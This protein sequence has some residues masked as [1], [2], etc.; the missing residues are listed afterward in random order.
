MNIFPI[1]DR[2]VAR[3]EKELLLDQKG[4]AFWLTGLSGSG[5]STIALAVERKLIDRKKMV[6]LLDGDNVR[7]GLCKDLS[8]SEDDRRENIRRISEL[9]KIFVENGLV[10]LCTFIS[11]LEKMRE[12]AKSIIGE[13]DFHL[14]FVD[15]PIDLCI[16]RDPKGLYAKAIRGEIDNFTGIGAPYEPPSH[17]DLV[18]DTAIHSLDESSQVLFDYILKF[19]PVK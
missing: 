1:H 9:V 6:I 12:E 7:N 8:F 19:I 18:I 14:V 11:P 13:D 4:Q 3:E 16:E 10:V 5:K 15:A 17:P 2:S